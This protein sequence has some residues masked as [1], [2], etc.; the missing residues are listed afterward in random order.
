[1][2]GINNSFSDAAERLTQLVV[3]LNV[4]GTPLL[5]SWP[6]ETGVPVVRVSPERYRNVLSNA[7]TSEPYLA[8][9]VEDVLS[10]QQDRFDLLAHSMGTLVAF[11]ALRL[12]SP[13]NVGTLDPSAPPPSTLPNVVLAAP[14]IG[15]K[16]FA[17][18]REEFIRKARRLTVYCGRDRAL[19][20]SKQVNGDER[21]G[22]CGDPKQQNDYI[23]GVE[24]VRVYGNY[25]DPFSHSYYINSPPILNDM[26]QAISMEQGA[27]AFPGSVRQ[28]YR[29]I[30]LNY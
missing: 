5:F 1:V 9:A 30:F 14:D 17:A 3:D 25:R 26:K 20:F 12:Q 27:S 15:M 22:Y 19:F 18:G 11:D 6:S 8:Q 23:E 16:H 4:K 13:K 7:T 21:L 10:S 24:F 29:E 28:P 2:H